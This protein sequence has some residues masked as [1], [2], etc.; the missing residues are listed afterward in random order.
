MAAVTCSEQK[1]WGIHSLIRDDRCT[2]CGWEAA[3]PSAPVERASIPT[4]A[5]RLWAAIAGRFS[6]ATRAVSA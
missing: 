5:E 1:P 3:S 6:A 2:R 4:V